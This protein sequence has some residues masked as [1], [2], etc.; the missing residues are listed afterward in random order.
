MLKLG[1]KV[2]KRGLEHLGSGTV[3]CVSAEGVVV[4]WGVIHGTHRPEELKKV[5]D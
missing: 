4:F 5:E 2:V 1:D 3:R